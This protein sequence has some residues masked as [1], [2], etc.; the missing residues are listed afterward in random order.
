MELQ[1]QQQETKSKKNKYRK[2]K[3]W[4]NDPTLDKWK[5]EEFKKG[6]MPYTLSEESSFATLFPQYREKYIQES[7][8]NIKKT[9]NDYGIKADLN[10][11]EGSITV[12]TTKKTWDPYAIIKA[13]DCIKLL[14]RSVP[15]QQALRVMEDGVFSDVVKIRNLVRNKE[16]F[17]KRRQRLIGPNGQTL[18]A[19]ELLT[20]CYI[21]VQGSTVSCIG[22]WKQ[23]KVLRRIIEDTMHNIH[24]IYN[25]KELMIKKELMKDDKLKDENWDRFLPQFKKINAKKKQKKQ[26]VQK[27][28]YTPFPPE[29]QPRKI[30]I[31]IQTGEYFLKESEKKQNNLKQKIIKQENKIQQKM[32]QKSKLY[33]AP[34]INK[35]IE[36]ENQKKKKKDQQFTQ[37]QDIEELKNKFLDKGKKKVKIF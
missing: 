36:K 7:F 35:E 34:E 16:K 6:D 8:G 25:I 22:G 26:K 20:E 9:L 5:I 23:L 10:L 29:Q 24:P 18:K 2:D 27:K 33:E 11:T 32:D 13:R 15:F 37:N 19:L 30:D 17:I 3:P 28:E 31:E 14:A 12:R 21:M 4:D 1:Q